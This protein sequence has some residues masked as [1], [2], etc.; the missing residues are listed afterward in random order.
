MGKRNFL[1]FLIFIVICVGAGRFFQ[2]DIDHSRAFFAQ[3][4]LL[5]SGLIFIVLYVVGTFFIWFGPKD[6]LRVAAVFIFGV[7][8]SSILIYIGEMMN[9]ALLF[10]LSRKMGRPFVA[11]RARGRMKRLEEAA[12]QTSPP[13]VFFL[14]FYP[15]M[16]LRLLDMG[17]GLTRIA[18]IKYAC[19]SALATPLRIYI[20]QYFLE[21]MIR[22]GLVLNGEMALYHQR[23]MDMT[24]H[25]IDRPVLFW[26]L[27]L[28]TF[29]A[30]FF[31]GILLA[32]WKSRK[33]AA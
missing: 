4:P 33:K 25:L 14:K 15:I 1:F 24:S 5:W 16:S 3:Y 22:F 10:G 12:S 20:V 11:A 28:Y 31:F 27:T 6:V 30:F 19:M 26:S 7:L 29:S 13:A 9:M 17:F 8:Q 23:F 18:F 32:R 21:M 2:L